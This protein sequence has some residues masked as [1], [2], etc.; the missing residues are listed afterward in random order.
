MKQIPSIAAVPALVSTPPPPSTRL[1]PPGKNC[2]V[3]LHKC[4]SASREALQNLLFRLF[5][6]LWPPEAHR[7]RRE[8]FLQLEALI[9]GQAA[10]VGGFD[11]RIHHHAVVQCVDNQL[12]RA[13]DNSRSA[14]ASHGQNRF[15]VLQYDS[16]GHA[17]KRRFSGTHRIGH[18]VGK[19]CVVL[20]PTLGLKSA[21]VLFIMKP[22]P[23]ITTP[24]PHQLRIV[25]V[26][27][28]TLPY[29]SITEKWE[30]QPLYSF[31]SIPSV[32]AYSPALF[33]SILDASSF[34][35]SLEMILSTC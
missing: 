15:P 10:H 19:A 25:W 13:G 6:G 3:L 5:Y 30:V 7:V 14:C 28:N 34:A 27:T 29:L 24:Q 9:S 4:R 16:R 20:T 22:L 11:C 26:C 32:G 18:A 33:M 23:G 17:G 1:V 31:A 2:P 35:Y 8:S 21:I 12:E